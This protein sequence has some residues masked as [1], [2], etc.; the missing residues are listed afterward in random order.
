MH[1]TKQERALQK[2]LDHHDV[3]KKEILTLRNDLYYQYFENKK[4]RWFFDISYKPQQ[5]PSGDSYSIRKVGEDKIFLFLVDAMGKGITASITSILSSSFLNYYVDQYDEKEE[6]DL[7]SCVTTYHD[8]IKRL[9]FPDEVISVSFM[10]FDFKENQLQSAVFGMPP[11]LLQTGD[12]VIESIKA[13]NFPLTSFLPDIKINTTNLKNFKKILIYTDGL[14]ESIIDDSHMYKK[15]MNDDFKNAINYKDFLQRAQKRVGTFDDD[16]TFLYIEK[17]LCCHCCLQKI[18]IKS[19]MDSLD[20][21]IETVEA[22]LAENDI[23]AKSSAYMLNA[24]IEVLINAYEHG[25]L[26]INGDEKALHME[27][28]TYDALV[29]A[30]ELENREKKIQVN[31]HVKE[32]N[33]QKT[34]KIEVKDVGDGFS[35]DIMKDRLLKKEKFNGRGLLMISKMVDAF[36]YNTKGNHVVLKIFNKEEGNKDGKYS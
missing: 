36:Y 3:F 30:K 26:G 34:L 12:D 10:L 7:A 17:E 24:F 25:N 4:G 20:G 2:D 6:F 15:Y 31:L 5:Q 16:M 19:H 8:Y 1:M 9:I 27:N 29:K 35:T 11:I 18:A 23:D 32:E 14:N 22:F 28:G 33:G 21:A 13:N